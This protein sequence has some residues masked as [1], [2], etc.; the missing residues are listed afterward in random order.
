MVLVIIIFLSSSCSDR[1]ADDQRTSGKLNVVATTG[2]LYDAILQIADTLVDATPIMGPGVDPHLYKAT[3]GDLKKLR[4]AD[5][6]I[7]NGLLLEGKMGEILENLGKRKPVY[8]AGEEIPSSELLS[9]QQYENAYD[10]HIWFDVN[11]WKKAVAG[12]S[13][14]LQEVDSANA[15]T[16]KLRTEQYLNALDTLDT[17]V[18]KQIES[19]PPTQRVLVTAHDA[20]GYFGKAYNIEVQGL[21][22]ISTVSDFGL[23]DIA[24]I[25][26]LI[27]ERNVKAIFVETSVSDKAIKAVINGCR[28]KGHEV[29]I[30]GN[31]YSDA[32]GEFG[33]YEGTYIGMVKHNVDVITESL[34]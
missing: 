8:A 12:I 31:L 10:P 23:K 25:T 21:Q 3:Q 16:Y 18:R 15:K 1:Q 26:D 20:F 7:Y 11:L 9:S 4:S 22:G 34:K 17:F 2:M 5:L 33:T 24:N 14:N 27:I 29:V 19:I 30:G 32:M 6:I 13:D 28:E